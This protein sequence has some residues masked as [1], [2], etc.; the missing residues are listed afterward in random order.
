MLGAVSSLITSSEVARRLGVSPASVKRWADAGLLTVARTGGGH[1]R[2][3]EEE[4][5]RFRRA[6]GAA[7]D[8]ASVWADRLLSDDSA[9]ALDAAL[10]ED[11]VRL[12]AWWRVAE[13]LERVFEELQRRV[14]A[15][16]I[17][18]VQAR[19][20]EARLERSLAHWCE[21]LPGRAQKTRA[22]LVA[23][24]D[25]RDSVR[26]TLVELTVCEWGWACRLAGAVAADDVAAHLAHGTVDAV[27]MHATDAED[28]RRLAE[29]ASR[30]AESCRR[31]RLPFACC[32]AA[33][34]LGR[35][36]DPVQPADGYQA[37]REWMATVDAARAH[38]A[39]HERTVS[40]ADGQ[41]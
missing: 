8:A 18:P 34:W 39:Q 29:W 4:V 12:G 33:R 27:V 32:G 9:L 38:A 20:A 26:L 30:I 13:A 6:R 31:Q 41:A 16:L 21:T 15:A 23:P 11:R 19:L 22:L 17:D 35:V 36:A 5:E 24:E 1:R 14:E 2:F 40:H 7:L 37:L 25:D 3:T 28:P 10:H